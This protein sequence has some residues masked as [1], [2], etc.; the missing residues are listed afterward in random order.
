MGA[1]DIGV[2]LRIF[3]FTSVASVVT[4][5][6]LIC[7]TMNDLNEYSAQG[8]AWIF[9]GFQ[10]TLIFCQYLIEAIIPD[11]PEE[12]EIQER[13]MNFIVSKVIFKT[14]DEDAMSVEDYKRRGHTSIYADHDLVEEKVEGCWRWIAKGG[15]SY[16]KKVDK[17][18]VQ[19]VNI[20]KYPSNGM[21]GNPM[22]QV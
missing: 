9:I 22:V 17:S 13:R 8:R 6:G 2:W 21:V 20:E 16:V 15:A 19:N 5:A 3:Q 1:Q 12:V 11:E 4:N 10:W 7:F 18:K 14:P